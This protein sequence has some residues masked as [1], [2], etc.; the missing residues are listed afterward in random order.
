VGRPDRDT[1]LRL[2]RERNIG[3]SVHYP[4]LHRMVLYRHSSSKQLAATDTVADQLL[5]LPI[6]SNMTLADAAE[7]AQHLLEILAQPRA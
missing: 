6:G 4:P 3:A 5:T 1:I 7:T 2:L